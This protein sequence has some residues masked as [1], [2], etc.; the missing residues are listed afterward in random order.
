M[1]GLKPR[2]RRRDFGISHTRNK[3]LIKESGRKPYASYGSVW[4]LGYTLLN[5]KKNGEM[6]TIDKKTNGYCFTSEGNWKQNRSLKGFD[7]DQNLADHPKYS[8]L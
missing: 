5:H 8:C 7:L 6:A 1:A 4:S 3:K 2:I